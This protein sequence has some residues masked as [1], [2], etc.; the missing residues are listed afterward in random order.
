MSGKDNLDLY[1]DHIDPV[2]IKSSFENIG[3]YEDIKNDLLS[4][5]KLLNHVKKL[6]SWKQEILGKVL[7]YGPPGTGKTTI[8]KA[9]AKK[10]NLPLYLFKTNNI[11]SKYISESGKNLESA[12]NQ[13]KLEENIILFIDE[14]DSIAKTRES[15]GDHDE[16]KRI[17]NTLLQSLDSISL[18]ENKIL[19]IAATNFET[20]LDDAIWRRFDQILY[21]GLPELS[22][23]KSILRVLT[24]DIP[25]IEMNDFQISSIDF[26]S[27]QNFQKRQPIL[28]L[29][30]G[31]T[32]Y[33]K[34]SNSYSKNN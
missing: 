29:N 12:I 11:L 17:V 28:K 10:S 25:K 9:L 22:S 32:V 18:T 14:F 24:D 13:I 26:T 1:F 21:M 2:N 6:K 16:H 20:I 7:L 30:K 31:S 5:T 27:A 19:L 33:K 15:T 23:R 3:G 4:F 8:V 34:I